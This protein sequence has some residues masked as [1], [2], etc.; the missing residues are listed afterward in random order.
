MLCVFWKK[1]EEKP[2]RTHRIAMFQ[3]LSTSDCVTHQNPGRPVTE[4]CA[5]PL[6]VAM[7]S[8]G[9][10]DLNHIQQ[11]IHTASLFWISS[12]FPYA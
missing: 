5:T 8:S 12:Y 1:N 2:S 11:N 9:C 10:V 3:H 4:D 7:P 6:V